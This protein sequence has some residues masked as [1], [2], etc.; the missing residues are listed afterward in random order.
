MLY[1]LNP[2]YLRNQDLNTSLIFNGSWA[3]K[4]SRNTTP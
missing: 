4:L 2:G 1:T 3:G